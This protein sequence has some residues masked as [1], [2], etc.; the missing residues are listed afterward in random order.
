MVWQPA[1][2][3]KVES[4]VLSFLQSPDWRIGMPLTDEKT[5]TREGE[6]KYQVFISSTFGD[7]ADQRRMVLDAVID[8]GHMPVARS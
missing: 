4:D 3:A 1:P 6:R 8:R 5:D 7:L 2:Q